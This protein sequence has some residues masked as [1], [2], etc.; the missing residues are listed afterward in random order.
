M[1]KTE[2]Q[3]FQAVIHPAINLEKLTP[4]QKADL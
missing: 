4:D 3:N 1:K 2:D